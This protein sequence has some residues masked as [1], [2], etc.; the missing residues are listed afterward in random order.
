MYRATLGIEVKIS[1]DYAK[2]TLQ[3]FPGQFAKKSSQ[4]NSSMTWSIAPLQLVIH[5]SLGKF[6]G[7][8]PDLVFNISYVDFEYLYPKKELPARP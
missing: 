7:R 2:P 5:Y 8:R 4:W 3:P 6:F 1:V